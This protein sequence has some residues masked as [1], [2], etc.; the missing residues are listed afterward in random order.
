MT[1]ATSTSVALRDGRRL[2]VCVTGHD[3]D[4]ALVQHHGTPGSWIQIRSMQRAAVRH[5]MRLV[6]MS[7]AGYGASDRHAGRRVADVV[8]DVADVLDHLGIER[9]FVGGWSGGGPHALATAAGLPGRV[10]GALVIAGVG[11]YR[12]SHLDFLAGMGQQNIEEFGLAVEGEAR[13]RPYLEREGATLNEATAQDIIAAWSTLL[14]EVDRAALTDEYGEDI[15]Y[16]MHEAVRT[17]VDG[18]LDD[19]LAF[20]QPWGFELADVR[21]P[22]VL[23]QGRADLMVPA[24]HAEWLAERLPDVRAHLDPNHGHMSWNL[25]LDRVLDELVETAA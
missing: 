6:T 3:G 8:T 12:A 9:C 22:V 19:D 2:D 17:G 16:Q 15:A 11:P 4:V 24:A 10:A 1:V 7:R 21:C 18:W 23:C 20:V 5:G 14:P 25:D 13:L